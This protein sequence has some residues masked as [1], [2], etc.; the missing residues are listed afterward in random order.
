MIGVTNLQ[1]SWLL[2]G[3]PPE[4]ERPSNEIS[5]IANETW[6]PQYSSKIKRAAP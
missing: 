6:L 5:L 2:N 4:I 1:M 3:N